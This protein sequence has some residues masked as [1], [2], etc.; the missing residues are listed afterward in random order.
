MCSGENRNSWGSKRVSLFYT[1]LCSCENGIEVQKGSYVL[2][3]QCVQ[4]KMESVEV[5]KGS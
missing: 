4:V 2:Y 1:C 5:W 3:L